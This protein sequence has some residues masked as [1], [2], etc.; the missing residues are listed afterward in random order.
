M[1]GRVEPPAGGAWPEGARVLVKPFGP[2]E[3]AAQVEAVL[4]GEA[5]ASRGG[6]PGRSA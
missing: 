3:L 5:G 6:D 2:D 1:T 4:D